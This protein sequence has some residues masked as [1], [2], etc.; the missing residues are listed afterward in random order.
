MAERVCRLLLGPGINVYG[1]RS[2]DAPGE[3]PGRGGAGRRR[4]LDWETLS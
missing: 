1:T 4:A 3:S 2:R